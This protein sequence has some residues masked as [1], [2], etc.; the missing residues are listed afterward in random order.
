[1]AKILI[2]W[3]ALVNDFLKDKKTPN[4]DGPTS[5]VHKY[6]FN[7]DYHILLSDKTKDNDIAYEIILNYLLRTYRTHKIHEIY[8][9]IQDKINVREIKAK[10]EELLLNHRQDEID[11]F[12]SPGTPSMQVAWY[13]AHMGLGLKTKLFQTRESKFTKNNHPEKVYIDLKKSSMT[14]SFM[15]TESINNNIE[16]TGDFLKTKSLEPIY[17]IAEK[18]A[19]TNDT[20]VLILGETGTGKEIL[21]KFI[22]DNSHRAKKPFIAINC[23]SFSDQLLESRLFGYAKGAYTDA[24]QTTNGYFQVANGGTIFLD[25]IGDTSAY[26]QQTLLRVLQEKKVTKVGASKEEEVDVRIITATNKDLMELCNKNE[27]RRDLYYR[28]SVV[29]FKLPSIKEMGF[30]EKEKILNWFIENRKKDFN[31]PLPEIPKHIKN[32]ILSH[33][34]PGNFRELNNIICRIYSIC[35]NNVSEKELPRTL[36]AHGK[37]H[38]FK[39][40]DAMSRHINNVYLMCDKNASKTARVLDIALNTVKKNLDSSKKRAIPFCDIAH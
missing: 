26:F 22:H 15:I 9:N 18:V 3:M 35:D 8:L 31:K 33:S 17:E 6:F 32:I 13:L 28:L 27:F 25:E 24:K 1:M 7:Y 30:K 5:E 2:S 40:K 12:I 39:L 20:P 21:A 4:P 10:I 37:E 14:S 11:I 29:D 23:A 16:D 34:F 19:G 36:S 38:S